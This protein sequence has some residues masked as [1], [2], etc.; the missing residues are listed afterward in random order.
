[1]RALDPNTKD[2]ARL[3]YV[4][5]HLFAVLFAGVLCDDFDYTTEDPWRVFWPAVTVLT[6]YPDL[7]AALATAAATNEWA[8]GKRGTRTPLSW[9]VDS[10]TTAGVAIL[11]DPRAAA[12]FE[13]SASALPV[14][15][16]LIVQS[17]TWT[18]VNTYAPND[19]HARE[20]LFVQLRAVLNERS[21]LVVA[22]DFNCVE[23]PQLDRVT[24]GQPRTGATESPAL[25]TMVTELDLVDA[26]TL[27]TSG[28]RRAHHPTSFVHGSYASSH[29]GWRSA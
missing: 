27:G 16:A 28:V 23:F 5:G 8:G 15:R 2:T 3:L 12:Q 10:S 6:R 24:D 7:S 26:V 4:A 17:P 29:A 21:Q 14:A 18:I 25:S 20:A 9:S 11:M 22:G 19:K 13:L 1:M